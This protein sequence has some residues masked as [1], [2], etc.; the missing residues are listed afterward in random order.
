MT[1]ELRCPFYTSDPYFQQIFLQLYGCAAVCA[2]MVQKWEKL[3][4]NCRE[5]LWGS[6]FAATT[7]YEVIFSDNYW[8]EII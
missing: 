7:K 1:E 6:M 4:H 3:Q 8:N 5:F 2:C